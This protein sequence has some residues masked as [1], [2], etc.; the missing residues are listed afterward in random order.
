MF[1][2]PLWNL[3]ELPL[4]KVTEKKDYLYLSQGSICVYLLA[5]TTN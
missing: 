4:L 3:W 2:L 5:A 1:Q